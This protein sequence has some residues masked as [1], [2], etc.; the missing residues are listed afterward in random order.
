[1]SQ[2][3]EAA[4]F[5][6]KQGFAGRKCLEHANHISTTHYAVHKRMVQA[7]KG[8]L[9]VIIL[10]VM[11]IAWGF[12]RHNQTS[13][14]YLCKTL[15]VQFGDD[16]RPEL[17]TF[18]GLYDL[19]HPSGLSLQSQHVQYIE[20]LSGHARF[21]FCETNSYWTVQWKDSP[22]GSF[23][24]SP[25]DGWYV[26][27]SQTASFDIT[28]AVTDVWFVRDALQRELILE[29]FFLHC[30]ECGNTLSAKST[31]QC[32][33][34]GTCSNAV[35]TCDEGWFGFRCEF[36]TP[37]PALDFDA[38]TSFGMGIPGFKPHEELDDGLQILTDDQSSIPV[39]AYSRPIYIGY[40][41]SGHYTVIF[42][43]GRR[44]VATHTGLLPSLNQTHLLL[45]KEA[46]R[47]EIL[48]FFTNNS[49]HAHWSNFAVEYLSEPMDLGTPSSQNSPESFGWYE[50]EAKTAITQVEIQ[51]VNQGRPFD[52][53]LICATCD[54]E[55]NPCFFDGVCLNSTC[56]C[57]IGAHGTRC[58]KS[59]VNNGRCDS[60]YNIPYFEL[61]GGDCCS[62]TCI[63]SADYTCGEDL[64]GYVNHGYFHCDLPSG[65]WQILDRARIDGDPL[66]LTGYSVALSQ[67][68]T[69]LAV[70]EPEQSRVKIFDKDGAQWILRES[71]Q[72]P[73]DSHFGVSVKVSGG[74]VHWRNN[75]NFRAPLIL[76][77]G[78]EESMHVEIFKCG[79][80][81]RCTLVDQLDN[82]H[83]KVGPEAYDISYD[84]RVLAFG[85]ANTGRVEVFETSGDYYEGNRTLRQ[86]IIPVEDQL[87]SAVYG[88]RLSQ[89]GDVLAVSESLSPPRMNIVR[90]FE[91]DGESYEPRGDPL[92]ESNGDILQRQLAMSANGNVVAIGQSE[93]PT[94]N[95]PVFEW[96]AA[97]FAWR[98][99]PSPSLPEESCPNTYLEWSLALDQDG[100]SLFAGA[101]PDSDLI[102]AYEWE[103]TTWKTLGAPITAP[104]PGSNSAIAVSSDGAHIVVGL[105]YA[106][107]NEAGVASTYSLPLSHCPTDSAHHFRL[108]LTTDYEPENTL[109]SLEDAES[110]EIIMTEGPYVFS[111]ATLV[112]E[113]C[114]STSN[115]HAFTI[116]NTNGHE[117]LERPGRYDLF[118]DGED[119]DRESF[120]G[121]AKR[122]F[123]GD[124]CLTCSNGTRMLRMM[125]HTCQQAQWMLVD[126]TGSSVATGTSLPDAPCGAIENYYWE[127]T[128]IEEAICY[129]FTAAVTTEG[130]NSSNPG[131]DYLLLYGDDVQITAKNKI[132]S[133]S[134]SQVGNCPGLVID[135]DLDQEGD[136]FTR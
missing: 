112:K 125:V 91:W 103:S 26:R 92:F 23:P 11:L 97:L 87:Q 94:L 88:I 131:L 134:S 21:A 53:R 78:V 24:A 42:F 45:G 100:R 33:G 74:P 114:L 62:A 29:P 101:Y 38:R 57:A 67:S 73:P 34:R 59:P 63:S 2:L 25:C 106:G 64:N 20:R 119:L 122:V 115:C 109:W 35:C 129:N 51:G 56:V 121:H 71:L 123:F 128:C 99:R 8:I 98:A 9:M 36:I 41:L 107:A 32:T 132:L 85:H 15:L 126:D 77:V 30:Y 95:L 118:L 46:G 43:S 127:E 61:D 89:N 69:L 60:N 55:F 49:F 120:S 70:G 83:G 65:R 116:Y 14:F 130:V 79:N 58:E 81:N 66:S 44:W 90:V 135:A 6:A 52:T 37:C 5:L 50:A 3:D 4:F 1:M 124:T 104:L 136:S 22:E 82:V 18:A 113:L 13:G 7:T 117:G 86:T 76:A 28:Q 75:P 31:S 110:G 93:C 27:S 40:L 84:G 19:Q 54:G 12:T 72:G 17:G 102:T 108:S 105:P 39:Q 111:L 68:G 80:N 47:E 133:S 16:L 10:V 48:G 96:D